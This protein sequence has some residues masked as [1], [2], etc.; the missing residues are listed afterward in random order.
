MAENPSG[1][2][3]LAGN[4]FTDMDGDIHYNGTTV[5]TEDASFSGQILQISPTKLLGYGAGAGGA[6]TQ[7]TSITT[8]VTLSKPCGQ[9]TTVASTLAAAAEAE[10]VVTNTLVSASDVIVVSTTY[11]GGGTPI[12]YV[13]KVA[14]GAFTVGITNVHASAALDAVV[15]IN[16]A[17]LNVTAA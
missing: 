16:F 15:V 7:I 4:P 12:I 10:F 17:V 1:D 5:Y 8:G 14:A 9:I 13:R 11:D 6:V 3:N 2:D